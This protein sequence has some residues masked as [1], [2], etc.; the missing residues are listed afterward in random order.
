MSSAKNFWA[1]NEPVGQRLRYSSRIFC[2]SVAID[3][4]SLFAF[5][6]SISAS[7][8]S[9]CDEMLTDARLSILHAISPS[10]TDERAGG[11]ERVGRERCNYN[12]GRPFTS[13]FREVM[14]M[15]WGAENRVGGKAFQ[16]GINDIVLGTVLDCFTH[17]SF[18]L[19]HLVDGLNPSD[20]PSLS[21]LPI[22][23]PVSQ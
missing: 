23:L 17:L 12:L 1:K 8:I 18:L 22:H 6:F 15:K 11:S 2:G 3:S 19:N 9:S 13:L 5:R 7:L 4:P 16:V 14:R 21:N 10:L 20:L